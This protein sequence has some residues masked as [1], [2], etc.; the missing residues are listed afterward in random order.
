MPRH[1]ADDIN[2]SERA[3]WEPSPTPSDE[4]WDDEGADADGN[5]RYEIIGEEVDWQGNIKHEVRWDDW[6]RSDGTKTTWESPNHSSIDSKPWTRQQL[7]RRRLL[8]AESLA[9]EIPSTVDIH[10]DATFLR[11]QA[12]D[13]KLERAQKEEQPNR[14]LEMARLMAKHQAHIHQPSQGASIPDSPLRSSQRQSVR[15][16]TMNSVDSSSTPTARSSS[17]TSVQSTASSNTPQSRAAAS[18]SSSKSRAQPPGRVNAPPSE[19]A[20][21]IVV[22]TTKPTKT[23]GAHIPKSVVTSSSSAKQTVPKKQIKDS[24]KQAP[25][26]PSASFG[27]LTSPSS[28]EPVRLPETPVSRVFSSHTALATS[29]K[30][31]FQPSPSERSHLHQQP[32]STPIDK[33]KGRARDDDLSCASMNYP[34]LPRKRVKRMAVT[35][36]TDTLEIIRSPSSM[37]TPSRSLNPAEETPEAQRKKLSREWTRAAREQGGAPITFFSDV[38]KGEAIPKLS[39]SFRY[40]ECSYVFDEGIEE[41]DSG[42][43]TACNCNVCGPKPATCS[44]QVDSERLKFAYTASGLFA[45][46]RS[47]TAEVVECNKLCKCSVDD[48]IN[49]VSQRPRDVPIQVFKTRALEWGVRALVPLKRG[50]VLGIYTGRLIRRESARQ[51]PLKESIYCF[52]LDGDE[53]VPVENLS[54]DLSQSTQGAQNKYS[55]DSLLEGNW[56]RFIKSKILSF[57]T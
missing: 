50:K 25:S 37:S 28:H 34:S 1:D 13:E 54:Q 11:S 49:R 22:S 30:P 7:R 6:Q 35:S 14:I 10:N 2:E 18:G 17:K 9:I 41:P 26:T 29:S 39:H 8:A 46:D 38:D 27:I 4:P 57:P 21:A 33:G 12:Y 31:S 43:L 19:L 3:R 20:S 52:D 45:F 42:F 23:Q 36:D 53:I 56:T 44:C 24:V 51:L 48:C 15:Q 16:K 5:W 40:L 47:E 32:P 55:V